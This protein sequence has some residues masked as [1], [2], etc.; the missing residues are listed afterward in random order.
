MGDLVEAV[1]RA[2]EVAKEDH[3]RV[4]AARMEHAIDG[5]PG[6]VHHDLR[7]PVLVR[8]IAHPSKLQDELLPAFR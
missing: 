6:G 5:A 3:A 2:P 4:A 1:G 7:G 8:A